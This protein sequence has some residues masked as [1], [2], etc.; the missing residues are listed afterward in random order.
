MYKP[1]AKRLLPLLDLTSLNDADTDETISTL[2]QKAVSPFGKV[3]AVC[4]Y[5]RFVKLAVTFLQGS[6]I[7]TATVVN[8]PHGQHS[9]NQVLDEIKYVLQQ[10]AKEI[11]LVFPYH[12]YLQGE[13]KAAMDMVEESKK[14]CENVILKVI[15]E[16]GILKNQEII[17]SASHDAILAG[18]D[19]LK[20]STGKTPTGATPEAAYSMLLTIQE[21][22]QSVGF[23]VSGGI[24][25]IDD[26]EIYLNL[27]QQI[28]G[29][30]WINKKTFRIGASRL[31]DEILGELSDG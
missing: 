29:Q 2:C 27:A 31:F 12:L 1:L 21:S 13:K 10:G 16:T 20:T 4:V 26:A 6:G 14:L 3:A 15:L 7:A 18:A 11:D 25:T 9:L 24:K 30:N 8:F 17:A 23:K 28:M 5:P 22:H 19:F